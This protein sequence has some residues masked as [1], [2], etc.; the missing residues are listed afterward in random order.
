MSHDSSTHFQGKI[1]LLPPSP[2]RK[3]DLLLG[4]SVQCVLTDLSFADCRKKIVIRLFG[5]QM[6]RKRKTKKP[7]AGRS[8]RIDSMDALECEGTSVGLG[9]D[10]SLLTKDH[11]AQPVL[12]AES[13]L[14][15]SYYK[16][17]IRCGSGWLSA[18]EYFNN[19]Y[20]MR[21][22]ARGRTSSTN[23]A[24]SMRSQALSPQPAL[25]DT[26]NIQPLFHPFLRLPQEIQELILMTAAGLTRDYELLPDMSY[27][28]PAKRPKSPISLS[29]LLRISPAITDTMQPYILHRT[30]FHFGLT[31]TTNFLWQLGPDNR[32]HV[33]RLAFHF[34]RSALLHCVRWLAPDQLF[35]LL[36]PPVQ[37]EMGGLPHF[38]RCQ[39]R[40]LVH[41]L[42]LTELIIDIQIVPSEDIPMV[43]RALK[44]SFGSVEKISFVESH[45]DGTIKALGSSDVR[46]QG[47]GKGTWRDMTNGYVERYKRQVGWHNYHFALEIAS[48]T[49]EE[50]DK[51]MDA[52]TGFFDC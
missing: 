38:W 51:R 49:K 46:L 47:V 21:L 52:D 10:T 22:G 15:S 42:H 2:H 1:S 29:T 8:M 14:K 11:I 45:L 31:G 48:M 41:E 35:D 39:L 5:P 16:L 32:T 6:S 30:A 27:R 43:V 37:K 40:A 7:N 19:L 20:F 18:R 13:A 34:G 28:A 4:K 3:E 9:D 24:F 33:R 36:Q 26:V 25:E 44:D 17:V 12:Q 23:N 50:L